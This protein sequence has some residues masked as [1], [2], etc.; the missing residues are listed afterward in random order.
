M[1]AARSLETY[2]VLCPAVASIVYF[3]KPA[4][5]TAEMNAVV[6][7]RLATTMHHNL[8]TEMK[9]LATSVEI[10]K[11]KSL[12][13]RVGVAFE[14]LNKKAEKRRKRS[15]LRIKLLHREFGL[16]CIYFFS[17]VVCFL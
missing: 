11:A 16:S 14:I 4:P 7:S 13:I 12:K 17:K 5:S 2:L 3:Q 10:F 9:V 15:R 1:G 8:P 6:F